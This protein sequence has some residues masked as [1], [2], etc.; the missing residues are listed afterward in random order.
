MSMKTNLSGLPL[1]IHSNPARRRDLQMVVGIGLLIC[2]AWLVS[3]PFGLVRAAPVLQ[4]TADTSTATSTE[5]GTPTSTPTSTVTPTGTHTP[6][7]TNTYQNRYQ[8]IIIR[9]EATATPTSTLTNTSTPT[10][11]GTQPT[12]TR[13][14]TIAPSPT[15]AVSVSPS[16]G[17]VGDT[18][19]FTAKLT[20]PG[21][22]PASNAFLSDSFPTNISISSATTTKGTVS[23]SDYSLTVSLGSLMPGEVITVTV[24]ARV[25]SATTTQTLTNVFTLTY[26]GTKTKTGST[27][28]KVNASG[29][30][31]TGEMPLDVA[32]PPVDWSLIFLAAAAVLAA[33]FTLWYG[34]SLRANEQ[35][36]ASRVILVGVLLLVGGAAAGASAAGGLQP[37]ADPQPLIIN[38]P[39]ASPT[40][41]NFAGFPLAPAT[42]D[43]SHYR[44]T[45]P[46][47]VSEL[48][49]YP[50]PSPTLFPTSESDAGPD[51]SSI[52]RLVIPALGLDAVVKYVPFNGETWLI[53]GL[54]Q[55]IAWLGNTSWPG[56][57]GNVGLAGHVTVRGDQGGSEDGPFRYLDQLKS[58]ETIQVYTEQNIYTY[59]VAQQV[60]VEEGDLSVLATTENNQLTLITCTDWSDYFAS[61]SKRLIVSASLARSE[62]LTT[63]GQTN[64]P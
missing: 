25:N 26:D 49:D 43:L 30:P 64:L 18:F 29:L 24:N 57:G 38:L 48:P 42:P 51:A 35:D 47:A 14:G 1:P 2:L 28:Y 21:A 54:K 61:Y 46:E 11:T 3:I 45:T 50:V 13:T 12:P 56:L 17:R 32:T 22:A 7:A 41:Q 62:P 44:F 40:P 9:E 31:G 59:I 34:F 52:T 36:G 4:S 63:R 6:T 60:V 53:A 15:V 19:K 39:Q 58:G 10:T 23:K 33:V 37:L 20:N 27:T 8:P 55:E 16:E 5:T